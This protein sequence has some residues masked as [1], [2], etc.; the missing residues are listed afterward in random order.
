[1]DAAGALGRLPGRCP[2]APASGAPD[3][4]GS[5]RNAAFARTARGAVERRGRQGRRTGVERQVKLLVSDSAEASPAV[6]PGAS[7]HGNPSQH[8]PNIS[9]RM[10]AEGIADGIADL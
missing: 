8:Q 3:A 10:D 6:S 4:G 5:R 1:M 2:G 9:N 7:S